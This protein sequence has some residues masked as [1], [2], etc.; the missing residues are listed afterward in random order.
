MLFTKSM[1]KTGMIVETRAGSR[2][3]VMLDTDIT[4]NDSDVIVFSSDNWTGLNGFNEELLWG[5][6]KN[7]SQSEFAKTVDIIKVFQPNLPSGVL[8]YIKE[9]DTWQ[10]QFN[11]L[12]ERK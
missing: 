8:C 7:G 10:Q 11:L 12:W 4:Y 9:G 6:D 3:I 1:L 2:A 5:V